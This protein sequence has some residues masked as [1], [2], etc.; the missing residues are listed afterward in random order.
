MAAWIFLALGLLGT[1]YFFGLNYNKEFKEYMNL[2]ADMVE[3][4]T[5]YMDVNQ[6]SVNFGAKKSI[7]HKELLKN[8]NLISMKVKDDK[9]KGFVIVKN[10]F[11]ELKYNAYIKCDKYTTPDYKKNKIDVN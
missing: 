6:V 3:A 4:A 9:C 1:L 10:S 2:E 11:G 7:S 8:N 5:I